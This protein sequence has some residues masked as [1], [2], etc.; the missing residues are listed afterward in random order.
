ML[1]VIY[2]SFFKYRNRYYI[3]P[4]IEIWHKD[5]FFDGETYSPAI[6]IKIS[7]IMWAWEI[8]FR[9]PS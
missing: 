2:N 3:I 4:A 9:K 7:W 8:I 6:A 5:Q 1:P